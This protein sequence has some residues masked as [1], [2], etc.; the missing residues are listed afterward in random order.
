MSHEVISGNRRISTQQLLLHAAKAASGFRSLGVVPGDRVAL[1]LRNDFSYFEA[2]Y[3]ANLAG[4]YSVPINWHYAE[5]EARYVLSDSGA[6]VL[7]IHADLYRGIRAAIP[8]ETAVL[9]VPTPHEI[10]SAYKIPREHCMVPTDCRTWDNWLLD[11]EETSDAAMPLGSF[12]YTSG[13]TG[14]PRAVKREPPTPEQVERSNRM[15]AQ[16]FGLGSTGSPSEITTVMT[17]PLYHSA[18]NAYGLAL[19]RSGATVVLQPRFDAENL[20]KLIA[21]HRVTHMHVVPVMFKRLLHLSDEVRNRHNV[22]SLKWVVH[23]A[24]PCPAD[25]KRQ[26]I[27]W[28][29]PVIYEYYGATETGLITLASSEDWLG[30]PGTVGRAASGVILRVLD[31]V[32]KD[33]PPGV[34]G[35]VACRN[36]DVGNFTYYHDDEKRRRVDRDGL[37]FLGDMGYL[38]PEGFLFL[39]DRAADVINSGGVN[40][41]P[42]EIESVIQLMPGVAD[43]V[44]FGIPDD[45]FGEAV[46]AAIQLRDGE[47]GSVESVTAFLNGRMAHYKIPKRIEFHEILPREDSGKIFRRK[48]RERHWAGLNRRI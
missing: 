2:S 11:F 37:I 31:E 18:P 3:A 24:A 38:D 7:V 43:C 48:L 21:R 13:T 17:G 14:R 8:D 25:L 39:C 16:A 34:I 26:M 30:R 19:A 5:D 22:R 33:C 20:L 12:I 47:L 28:W 35:E 1:Y 27:D 32:G 42:A 45:E 4:A 6:K 40:I 9:V 41:Y 23:G 46:C 10:Q 29:G 36:Q 44:A 15:V